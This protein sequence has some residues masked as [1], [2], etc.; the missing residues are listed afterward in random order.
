MM[1]QELIVG[2]CVLIAAVFIVR[3]YLPFGQK[4]SGSCGGCTGCGDSKKSCAK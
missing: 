4:K 3:R 1:W 2:A